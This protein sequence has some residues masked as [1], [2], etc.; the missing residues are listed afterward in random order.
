MNTILFDLLSAQPVGTIKFHGGGEYI[1]RVFSRLVMKYY[2]EIRIIA[3]FDK[4]KFMDQWVRDL[5]L[6]YKVEII[7]INQLKEILP[8]FTQ[9]HI[10][11]FYSG[12]PYEYVAGI[13]PEKVYK[14]ATFHGLRAIECPTDRFECKYGFNLKKIIK[15]I[16]PTAV[17][18]KKNYKKMQQSIMIFDHIVTVSNHSYYAILKNYKDKIK[19]ITVMYSPQKKADS[20]FIPHNGNYILIV[21]ANRWLKNAYRGLCAIEQLY[22]NNLIS[23]IK[24]VVVGNIPLSLRRSLKNQGQYIFKGYVETEELEQLYAGCRI[25]LYP[26]LNEGFGYPPLEAMRYGKTCVVSA[27]CSLPEICGDAVYYINPYDIG[28]IS[29]RILE[30][31]DAPMDYE[32][33]LQRYEKILQRQENDLDN[34]V[35]LIAKG[36]E[37]R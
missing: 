18:V 1:K 14:I 13:L 28:E 5:I 16:L 25:F 19:R 6:E 22:A 36:K 26:T 9:Y 24:T 11:V 12:L 31:I 33:V 27:V 7:N 23:D 21:S 20:K 34:L 37:I 17:L 30:A 29:T 32:M 35:E 2:N 10:D 4:D 3:F 8:L 15:K